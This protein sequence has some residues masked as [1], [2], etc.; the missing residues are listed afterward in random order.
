MTKKEVVQKMREMSGSYTVSSSVIR[1]L[2]E[3]VGESL[4][5]NYNIEDFENDFKISID[6]MMGEFDYCEMIDDNFVRGNIILENCY[7]SDGDEYKELEKFINQ[8][9]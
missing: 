4:E 7:F 1:N 6:W 3:N 5:G 2:I 8:L 9:K